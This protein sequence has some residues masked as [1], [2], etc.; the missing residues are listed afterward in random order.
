MFND[1]DSFSGHPSSPLRNGAGGMTGLEHITVLGSPRCVFDY[2]PFR[3]DTVP[4]APILDEIS[5]MT[6]QFDDGFSLR[7]DA[8]ADRDVRKRAPGAGPKR[9]AAKRQA[10]LTARARGP[11][12]SAVFRPFESSE[13]TEL[14]VQLLRLWLN[15]TCTA[16]EVAKMDM[17]TVKA[18]GL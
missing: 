18:M 10:V 9:A 17:L 5:A 13:S 2:P 11:V 4:V 6:M 1:G 12:Q 15:G 16:D 14:T 7:H 3:S 8:G